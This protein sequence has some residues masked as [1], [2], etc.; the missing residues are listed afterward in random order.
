MVGF[1]PLTETERDVS[2]IFTPADL[3]CP[4]CNV[5]NMICKYNFLKSPCQSYLE[6]AQT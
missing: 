2:A 4:S 6:N 3:G 5:V 1:F